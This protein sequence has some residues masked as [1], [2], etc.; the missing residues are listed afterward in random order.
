MKSNEK[1]MFIKCL[2]SGIIIIVKVGRCGDALT[3]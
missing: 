3:R 2:K 1:F